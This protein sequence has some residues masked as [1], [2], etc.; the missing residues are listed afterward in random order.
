MKRVRLSQFLQQ[1]VDLGFHAFVAQRDNYRV[2]IEPGP[3]IFLDVLKMS[4]IASGPNSFP[5][6][7]LFNELIIV[8]YGDDEAHGSCVRFYYQITKII[9]CQRTK[10]SSYSGVN[11][12]RVLLK[13]YLGSKAG[14]FFDVP[15]SCASVVF[16]VFTERPNFRSYAFQY[17]GNFRKLALGFSRTLYLVLLGG[18]VDS[19]PD[20]YARAERLNPASPICRSQQVQ[21]SRSQRHREPNSERRDANYPSFP[22]IREDCHKDI[23]A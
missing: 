7:V 22:V 21:A 2:S 17:G 14:S 11:K 16:K 23:L 9:I 13:P 3:G 15:E 1:S 18:Y 20:A 4:V 6:S 5:V 8:L 12:K 19:D 10:F